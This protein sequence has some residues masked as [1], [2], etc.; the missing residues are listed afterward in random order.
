MRTKMPVKIGAN[1][2]N[3]PPSAKLAMTAVV[4]CLKREL[5][6]KPVPDRNATIQKTIMT[7]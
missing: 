3:T 7:I 2:H 1:A 4:V 5:K 6:Y